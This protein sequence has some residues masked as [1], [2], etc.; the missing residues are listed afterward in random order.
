MNTLTL[1]QLKS[2]VPAAFAEE[3]ADKVSDRYSF[4][5]TV[6]IID[7]LRERG[8]EPVSARQSH[9]IR[10]KRHALHMI[11]FQPIGTYNMAEVGD[12]VPQIYLFNSHDTSR[13]FCLRGGIFRKICANG[14][15]IS[16]GLGDSKLLRIHIDG[17]SVNIELAFETTLLQLQ[18]AAELVPQW[19]RIQM[20]FVQQLDF[21]AAGVLIR[22]GNDPHWSK[23]FDAHEFLTRRRDEDKGH[24]LWTVFNVLQENIIKGGVRGAVRDTRPITQVKEIQ[25]INEG[26]W[27][28]AQD[29]GKLHGVN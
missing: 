8:W 19:Q 28:L 24:D 26:L 3:P 25:R 2:I 6:P 14:A 11:D 18:Q 12:V 5:P 16:I 27:Q 20:N 22:T 23:H 1:D 9:R 4:I 7:A 10:D 29:Y 13:R 17:A 15:V 21:A